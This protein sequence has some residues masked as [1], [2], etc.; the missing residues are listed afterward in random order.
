ME[1]DVDICGKYTSDM[2]SCLSADFKTSVRFRKTAWF[3]IVLFWSILQPVISKWMFCLP[4]GLLHDQY[5]NSDSL[6]SAC[7]CWSVS[8]HRVWCPLCVYHTNGKHWHY[9]II[10]SLVYLWM[11]N[12]T[13]LSSTTDEES[14]YRHALAVLLPVQNQWNPQD[15][16]LRELQ[17]RSE[18]C[19]Q[20][21]YFRPR[22][23]Y[24]HI[25]RTC[26]P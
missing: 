6:L 13:L 23:N 22:W 21:K 7:V 20:K 10:A 3:W 5:S 2:S 25:L 26:I 1:S 18:G 11:Y 24:I 8:D 19:G 12:T 9:N 16:S 17:S 4:Y 15:G 14:G